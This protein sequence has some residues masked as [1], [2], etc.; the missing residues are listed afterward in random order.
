MMK[1][2]VE[3]CGFMQRKSFSR[4][5]CPIARSLE[6]VGEG[7]SLL[8]LRDVFIG[9]RRFQ[10]LELRLGISAE[11]ADMLLAMSLAEVVKLATS[12]FVLCAF[13]LD[14]LPVIRNVVQGE[15]ARSL[16]Q[17]H[18]SIVLTGAQNAG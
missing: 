10:D 14:E 15:R 17:A 18:L 12:N 13:R 5:A 8:I 9:V 1:V 6:E 16:Q 11:M 2:T 7:W 3:C 4:M